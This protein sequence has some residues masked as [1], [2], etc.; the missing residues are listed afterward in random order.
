MATNE[1][2]HDADQLTLPV[3]A[4]CVSGSPVQVGGMVGVCLNTRDAAGNATVKMKG[5]FDVQ[6]TG[7]VTVGLPIYITTATG[8][9]VI[10]AGVGINL[11]GHAVTA[12]AGGA[13]GSV[14]VRIAQFAVPT[15]TLA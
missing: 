5:V 4:Y 10:A 2:F 6:V 3:P 15:D 7:V 9:L 13:V 14:L 11:F 12:K 8:A 1:R